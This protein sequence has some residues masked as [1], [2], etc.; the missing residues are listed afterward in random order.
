MADTQA[1]KIRLREYETL[2][3]VKPDLSDEVV[4]KIKE[5]LRAA[6]GKD[7][8]KVLK[9]TLWGKKKT[10]FPVSKQ[11]RASYVHMSFLGN[12]GVVAE[13]ERNLAIT[14]DVTKYLSQYIAGDIDPETRQ[15][16]ADVKLAG[17]VDE[18]PRT[19]REGAP[20][21]G[22]RGERGERPERSERRDMTEG[23]AE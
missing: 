23:S 11:P 12:P 13:V 18:K 16:E 19:E 15:V 6:V 21:E 14:E 20:Y 3:L 10:A 5:R 7:G 2:F 8:G 4:D 22:E 17:D 9:F 1:S